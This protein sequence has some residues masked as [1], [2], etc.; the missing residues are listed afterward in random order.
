MSDFENFLNSIAFYT[1]RTGIFCV[2]LVERERLCGDLPKRMPLRNSRHWLRARA[3]LRCEP[4]VKRSPHA[5]SQPRQ[6]YRRT[7]RPRRRK[8]SVASR[9]S[10]TAA[11][12]PTEFSKRA[13]LN[14]PALIQNAR[15]LFRRSRVL[16]WSAFCSVGFCRR[17][18]TA[19]IDAYPSTRDSPNNATRV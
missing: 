12:R 15:S 10:T 19:S 4:L 14:L 2:Q 5:L 6:R 17:A 8:A 7:L 13:F 16:Y 18:A 1:L 9:P 3:A 11:P